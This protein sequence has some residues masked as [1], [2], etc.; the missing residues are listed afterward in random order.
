[1]NMPVP[2][3]K[4]K[5]TDPDSQDPGA[6]R[7]CTRSASPPALPTGSL[8]RGEEHP[9]V[10][11]PQNKGRESQGEEPGCTKSTA[12]QGAQWRG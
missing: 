4:A 8:G 2:R 9:S 7:K 11:Q 5:G 3:E 1:M 6:Q 10:Q 12:S